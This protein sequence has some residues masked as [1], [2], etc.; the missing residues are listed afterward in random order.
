M[1]MV[2]YSFCPVF[3]SL[4]SFSV[5]PRKSFSTCFSVLLFSLQYRRLLLKASFAKPQLQTEFF[6]HALPSL[7][8]LSVYLS[9]AVYGNCLLVFLP[10]ALYLSSQKDRII[11]SSFL[12]TPVLEHSGWQTMFFFFFFLFSIILF[13]FFTLQY[14]IGF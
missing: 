1:R 8:H 12:F 6:A 10:T 3:F 13:Y 2:S 4:P 7:V 11:S 14:C 5:S 9:I